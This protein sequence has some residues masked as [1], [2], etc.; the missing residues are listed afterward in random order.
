LATD[1]EVRIYFDP[2]EGRMIFVGHPEH[3]S[4]DRTVFNACG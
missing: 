3:A 1:T 4:F 2:S